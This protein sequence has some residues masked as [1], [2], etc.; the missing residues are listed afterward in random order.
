MNEKLLAE[1]IAA[2]A[3]RTDDSDWLDV[4][5]RIQMTKPRRNRT[6][7]G[8]VAIAALVLAG[9]ALGLGYQFLDLSVGDP[10]PPEV[11][12]I[13]DRWEQHR[14]AAAK[15]MRRRVGANRLADL[16]VGR[17]RLAGRLRAR[18]GRQVLFWT[19]P[20]TWGWCYAI[21]YVHFRNPA[22]YFMQ[23]GCG[24]GPAFAFDSHSFVGGRLYA[25]RVGPRVS[26]LEVRIGT[27][28]LRR[29]PPRRIPLR[30]G[31][32]L[33][34]APEGILARIVGRDARGRTLFV[35]EDFA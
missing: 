22:R 8:A 23:G 27:G 35:R 29:L 2:V 11:Q 30:N 10:A 20:T 16:Y 19:A 7:V 6:T 12:R 13:F 15:E 14:L 26:T 3:D 33:F 32:Y 21:Q 24:R 1:R 25:G 31:F 17:A 18:N 28:P 5:R 4:R 9:A 34:D